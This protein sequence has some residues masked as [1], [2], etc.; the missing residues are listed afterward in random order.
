MK[1]AKR[2]IPAALFVLAVGLLGC[3]C[4]QEPPHS[5]T[6]DNA[7]DTTCNECEQTRQTEH[8]FGLT[9]EFTLN[10]HTV[11]CAVCGFEA[12]KE[13]SMQS[14][15]CGGCPFEIQ[16]PPDF[17]TGYITEEETVIELER[18]KVVID[19]NVYI[20]DGV[21]EKLE[22]VLDALEAVTGM[23]F[24]TGENKMVILVV[25]PDN[26]MYPMSNQDG[27]LGPAQAS[28]G[29]VWNRNYHEITISSGDFFLGNSNAILHECAH[30]LRFSQVKGWMET[31]L[32]EGFAEY[33]SH[34]AMKYLEENSPELASFVSSSHM[35]LRD[36]HMEHHLLYTESLEYWMENGYPTE[37]A[38]N[39]G[40][41]VGYRFMAYLDDVYGD[42]SRWVK[43]MPDSYS[44]FSAREE[45]SLLKRVYG[46]DVIDG[47]Y[48]WMH[49][50][51][52]QYIYMPYG[53]YMPCDLT[54][55]E[56][57]AFYPGFNAVERFTFLFTRNEFQI[58]YDDLY[59]DIEEAR[60]YLSEYKSMDVD[61]LV[62]EISPAVDVK[63]YNEDG[64][65]LGIEHQREIP[66]D[67]VSYICLDGE[68]SVNQ[69]EITGYESDE[70]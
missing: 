31:I 58:E 8:S 2:Y 24:D 56:Y 25:K 29:W 34:K 47:F 66:L 23:N 30:A 48:P 28:P 52:N 14:G 39:G 3:G 40:Y 5:H 60:R 51:E 9:E 16:T 35:N 7:C 1:K 18:A 12:E 36:M 10:G 11:Q 44:S 64:A 53:E 46:D 33:T 21:E 13:H 6:Y 45:I 59:I 42:Y 62:L 15:Q 54:G 69:V 19:P 37:Y 49:E 17:G 50:H 20:V 68:G 63:L 43:E 22:A 57:V 32:E 4:E 61:S 67:G 27:E 26:S 38:G 55:A 65:L 41:C 70:Q